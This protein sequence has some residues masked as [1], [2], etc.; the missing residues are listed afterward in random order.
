MFKLK[1]LL[2]YFVIQKGFDLHTQTPLSLKNINDV[3]YHRTQNPNCA[4]TRN[5]FFVMPFPEIERG[6]AKFTTDHID[7]YNS[8]PWFMYIR[9][10]RDSHIIVPNESWYH[11]EPDKKRY[12][13]HTVHQSVWDVGG[14]IFQLDKNEGKPL[15]ITHESKEAVLSLF[16]KSMRKLEKP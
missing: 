5:S 6:I 15:Y 1:E 13:Q 14:G 11:V 3:L 12:V 2:Q 16:T 8:L 4:Q 10:D 9:G 7:E